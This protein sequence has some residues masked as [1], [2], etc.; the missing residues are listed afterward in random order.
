MGSEKYGWLLPNP[1][2]K[3]ETV[4]N[5]LAEMVAALCGIE[6]KNVRPRYHAE[7][8]PVPGH[9]TN[10]CALGIVGEDAPGGAVWHENGYSRLLVDQEIEALFSFYGP[11]ARE[12]ARALRDGLW[13]EQNRAIL[14]TENNIAISHMGAMQKV[15]ELVNGRW[16][17]RCDM[18]IIFIRGP[19][20]LKHPGQPAE[21]D[22]EIKDLKEAKP[23]GF[24]GRSR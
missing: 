22:L 5:I 3:A 17:M 12:K 1:G 15:P 13:V 18:T 19:E 9:K 21:G 14:R 11:L 10:W 23:C 7:S 4:E 8:A 24:C 6:P 2:P 20:I 16:L